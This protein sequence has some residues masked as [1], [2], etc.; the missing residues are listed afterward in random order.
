LAPPPSKKEE[1]WFIKLFLTYAKEMVRLP[2]E[3][4]ITSSAA[5]VFAVVRSPKAIRVP[6]VAA[7]MSEAAT[8]VPQPVEVGVGNVISALVAAEL[9]VTVKAVGATV[10]LVYPLPLTSVPAVDAV[11]A[12]EYKAT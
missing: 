3:N 12:T 11:G 4:F 10:T 9:D 2:E 5:I 7:D 1:P 8:T 6:S